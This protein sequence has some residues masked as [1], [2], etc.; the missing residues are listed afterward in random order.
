VRNHGN[1]GKGEKGA[2]QYCGGEKDDFLQGGGTGKT[3]EGEKKSA[4]GG[5]EKEGKVELATGHG[6]PGI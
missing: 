2:Y 1:S 4:G 3:S 6:F 5:A